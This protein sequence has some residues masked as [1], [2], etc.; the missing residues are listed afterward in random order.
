[1][2][3]ADHGFRVEKR[4]LVPGNSTRS[5]SP[6]VLSPAQQHS[7]SSSNSRIGNH[8]RMK[9]TQG[10]SSNGSYDYDVFVIGGG[11]GGVRTANA[12]AALGEADKGTTA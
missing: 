4:V 1:M 5:L 6:C 12:S 11:S 3:F 10:D 8:H 9:S 7:S 2:I